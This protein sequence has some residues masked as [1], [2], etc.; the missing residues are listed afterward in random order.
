M[1]TRK[2][3]ITGIIASLLLAVLAAST[4]NTI[5]GFTDDVFEADAAL[6]LGNTVNADGNLSDR[7]RG[8]VERGLG[9]YQSGLV[10]KIVVSGGLG[11]EGH[12]EGDAM[13]SWLA[14][15]GVPEVDII[16]DNEGS[17]TAATAR[18]FVALR[19]QHGLDSVIVVSQFFHVSRC[20]LALERVGIGKIGTAHSKVY[21]WRDVYATLREVAAYGKYFVAY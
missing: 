4:A 2:Q 5:D 14:A 3:V 21:E 16:V 11:K 12:Y 1:R 15:R 7:L 19:E 9:L 17:N 13:A 6:I 8:R 20:R 18:N 10:R